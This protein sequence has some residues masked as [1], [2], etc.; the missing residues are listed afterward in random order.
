MHLDQAV[1]VDRARLLAQ[2]AQVVVAEGGDDQQHRVGAVDR[3]LVELVGIDDE[4][5]A[6]DRQVA[7]RAGGAQVGQRAA[8]MRFVG[9]D[10]EGGRPAPLV[11]GDLGG[12]VDLLRARA[13]RRWASGA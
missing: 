2:R 12:E 8:E 5:L 6:D 3:R 11:G 4:V 1:E 9:E 7:G 10:R 13:G